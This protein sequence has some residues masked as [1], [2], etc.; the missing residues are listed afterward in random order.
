MMYFGIETMGLA[1]DG[2]EDCG[3]GADAEGKG[4]DGSAGEARRA[5]Q[6]ARGRT[7]RVPRPP[8]L[9]ALGAAGFGGHPAKEEEVA[10]AQFAAVREEDP[11]D[12]F[13]QGVAGA[14][15]SEL[16]G[17]AMRAVGGHNLQ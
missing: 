12:G 10:S 11:V 4:E 7:Q 15:A 8:H 2:G 16:D 9:C 14:Y 6:G 17:S 1:A 5:T 13:L 3:V